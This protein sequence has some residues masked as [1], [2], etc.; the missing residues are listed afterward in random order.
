MR[1]NELINTLNTYSVYSINFS[2]S[3]ILFDYIQTFMMVKNTKTRKYYI[4]DS[5]YKSAFFIMDNIYEILIK[6][7]RIKRRHEKD[8]EKPIFEYE[9][10][11][12]YLLCNMYIKIIDNKLRFYFETKLDL[13]DSYVDG[14][15]L[16]KSKRN[17]I[18][19][20][21]YLMFYRLNIFIDELVLYND[22]VF[23]ITIDE[24]DFLN[25][26]PEF[27]MLM[28]EIL[29]IKIQNKIRDYSSCHKRGYSLSTE[30][31]DSDDE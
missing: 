17:N 8:K 10:K 5:L 4:N 12:D 27:I 29:K 18:I 28:K 30:C 15:I 20:I 31:G 1:K 23:Y 13:E 19:N 9:F 6:Y 22:D 2:P 16:L 3:D 26:S 11:Y 25:A 14:R 24:K 21:M 7:N